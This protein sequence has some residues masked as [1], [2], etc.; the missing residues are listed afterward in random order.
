MHFTKQKFTLLN[1]G[2]LPK[3]RL[4]IVKGSRFGRSHFE[5]LTKLSQLTVKSHLALDASA[6]AETRRA[7]THA[8][9]AKECSQVGIQLARHLPR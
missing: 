8:Q 4:F 7:Q 1:L 9:Y 2:R 3:S 5:L 6:H